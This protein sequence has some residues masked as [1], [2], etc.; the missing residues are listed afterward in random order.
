M[1][2]LALYIAVV[3]SLWW[4]SR[5]GLSKALE[6]IL[7]VLIPTALIVLVNARFGRLLFRN[8]LVGIISIL[9]TAVFIYRA[10]QPLVVGINSWIHRKTNDF[11]GSPDVV[12]VEVISKED[13]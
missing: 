1:V 10:S 13:A 5:V 9:P 12:E 8:P 11:V 2:Y 4:S 3:A 7:S 6:T